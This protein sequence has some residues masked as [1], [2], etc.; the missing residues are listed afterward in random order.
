MRTLTL[1]M[2]RTSRFYRGDQ[3][4][5]FV[6][7]GNLGNLPHARLTLGQTLEKVTVCV[8]LLL[9]YYVKERS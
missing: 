4:G 3:C 9:R 8:D 2:G 5:K 6:I 1:G 7:H